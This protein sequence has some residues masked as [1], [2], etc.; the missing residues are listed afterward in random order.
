MKCHQN[1]KISNHQKGTRCFN[2]I[3]KWEKDAQEDTLGVLFIETVASYL[4]FIR[5]WG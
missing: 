3:I 2:V 1:Q 5:S 4:S